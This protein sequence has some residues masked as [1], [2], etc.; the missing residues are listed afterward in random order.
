M[1]HLPLA[2]VTG[3]TKGIGF[4]IAQELSTTHRLALIFKSDVEK[5]QH[6][7]L[8]LKK[9]SVEAEIFQVD[10][11]KPT[12]FH[13]T[14]H[15]I[16]TRFGSAPSVLINSAGKASNCLALLESVE[17]VSELMSI[18]FLGAVNAMNLVIPDMRA[19]GGGQIINISS[20]DAGHA[21][22]GKAAYSPT[23]VALE[24]YSHVMA[25]SLAQQKINV[26]CIRPGILPTEMSLEW[27]K[28][29]AP[30]SP[31]YKSVLFPSGKLISLDSVSD[32]VRFLL[33]TPEFNDITLTVDGGYSA[34]RQ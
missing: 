7:F 25:G 5:A 3:G 14:Y 31:E 9:Q 8:E 30:D 34:F 11:T 27:L 33:S 16:K 13:S 10:I 28:A 6:S 24:E 2:L 12:D 26:C 18:N 1:N 29:L 4:R 21:V 19:N 32:A 20:N 15:Q 22:R 17:A 23:K